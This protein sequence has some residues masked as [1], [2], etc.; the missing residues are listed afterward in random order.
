MTNCKG[1]IY[2][3]PGVRQTYGPRVAV[4]GAVAHDRIFFDGLVKRT[5]V[6]ALFI[7]GNAFRACAKFVNNNRDSRFYD[8]IEILAGEAIEDGYESFFN[9]IITSRFISRGN[10]FYI[11]S[12]TAFNRPITE[13]PTFG[14]HSYGEFCLSSKDVGKTR[15]NACKRFMK[16]NTAIFCACSVKKERPAG[17][18]TADS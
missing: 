6:I 17:F 9:M 11:N 18:S 3:F 13:A 14:L 12:I 8:R 2:F 16:Y 1:E 10:A 5:R 4:L 15:P 7:S